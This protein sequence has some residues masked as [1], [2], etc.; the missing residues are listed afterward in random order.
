[1]SA[2]SY[3]RN[4]S[5]HEGNTYAALTAVAGNATEEADRVI[6]EALHYAAPELS[7][8]NSPVLLDVPRA[9]G[10]FE[11]ILSNVEDEL[12]RV[13]ARYDYR[14]LL[15]VS[16]LCSMVP[17]LMREDKNY[18]DRR[19]RTMSADRWILRCAPRSLARD[20]MTMIPNDYHLMP[21][22]EALC[23]DA[24]KLHV[25]AHF[26]QRLVVERARFN[27]MRL[28]SGR[29]G[30][31]GPTMRVHEN[32]TV[33]WEKLANELYGSLI[34][35]YE[36][37]QHASE[38]L[39]WWGMGSVAA[40]N[41]FFALSA[42]PNPS[43]SAASPAFFEPSHI[44]LDA[45]LEYGRRF[46]DLFERDIGMPAE[47]F[48]AISRALGMLGLEG[49]SGDDGLQHWARLTAT[50]PVHRDDLL[51]G[52]LTLLATAELRELGTLVNERDLER[53][54]TRYVGLASS[55]DGTPALGAARM[56]DGGDFDA[57]A[58][59]NPF[60]PYMIHGT[61]Q[62][63][64]WIVDYLATI[65]FIRGVVNEIEFSDSTTVS[66]QEDAYVRTS[67]FDAHLAKELTSV[68][69]YVAAFIAHREEPDLPNAKFYFN[70]SGKSTDREIDVPL[71]RGEVLIAVQTWTPTVNEK[72][73]AGEKRALEQRWNN[74]RDKLGDTDQKYT[75][76]LLHHDEGRRL[77]AEE[78]LRCVLP[79][80]CGPYAEPLVSL[81]EKFWLRYPRFGFEG[82]LEGAM[83][84]VLT[85]TELLTFI[86][87]VTEPELR[88]ICEREGW[89]LTD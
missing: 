9:E 12:L 79:V 14:R 25:L 22:P 82:G 11:I 20:Y 5:L 26:H 16:R 89:V 15:H 42:D 73:R 39:A 60:Y 62:H 45:W 70:V 28:V 10:A 17:T 58:L 37:G 77:M 30:I 38:A 57:D 35:F 55:S 32:T 4:M 43:F 44:N 24:A 27:F 67:V 50:I 59:R 65:P 68:P 29:N 33:G 86:E 85:P 64:Y 69:G 54:V 7:E 83:P 71:R 61:D 72:T 84:R 31:P 19:M 80:L 8:L 49:A 18:E 23:H 6:L 34:L 3:Q 56:Q 40:G 51:G 76:Y 88:S 2:Y 36:R 41:E 48:W 47:H 46:G 1:M 74:A 63:D 81:K 21:V 13:C 75:D 78:G 66:A 87:N 52:R 53:S